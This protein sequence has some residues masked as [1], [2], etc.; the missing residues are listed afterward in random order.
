MVSFSNLEGEDQTAW[1]C[2]AESLLSLVIVHSFSTKKKESEK[3]FIDNWSH[4][5]LVLFFGSCFLRLCFF[6]ISICSFVKIQLGCQTAG[7]SLKDE[8]EFCFLHKYEL[9]YAKMYLI[10]ALPYII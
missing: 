1:V 6:V 2:C 3:L 4:D 9:T 7:Q 5:V 10:C 8:S